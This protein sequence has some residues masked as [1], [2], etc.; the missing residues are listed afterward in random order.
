MKLSKNKITF[1]AIASVVLTI[2]CVMS[3]VTPT[4]KTKTPNALLLEWN[5]IYETLDTTIDESV[6]MEVWGLREKL[7]PHG[8]TVFR[9]DPNNVEHQRRYQRHLL[10]N[11]NPRMEM[12]DWQIHKAHSYP[13]NG[14]MYDESCPHCRKE[15]VE[16]I[17]VGIQRYK[18]EVE[19]G[20]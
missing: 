4:P 13:V 16:Y 11:L 1:L 9:V 6:D 2:S 19:M 10:G 18:A 17:N 3:C 8:I 5:E 15:M 14:T 7:E 20:V 12:T